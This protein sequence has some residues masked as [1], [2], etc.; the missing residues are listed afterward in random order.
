MCVHEEI[1]D[2]NDIKPTHVKKF[3]KAQKISKLL[4]VTQH[5]K[6]KFPT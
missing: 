4:L 1:V 5:D 6:P 2:D 3:Y